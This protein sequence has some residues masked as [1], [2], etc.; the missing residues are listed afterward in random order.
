MDIENRLVVA[1][2]RGM[3]WE[4][5][6]SRC[7]LLLLEW[8]SNGALLCSTENFM[9]SLLIQHGRRQYEKKNVMYDWVPF[10]YSRNGQNIIN[11]L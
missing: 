5:G 3:D 7:T 4:S 9:Q 8:I 6:V 11:Q 2:G 10:L 1:G